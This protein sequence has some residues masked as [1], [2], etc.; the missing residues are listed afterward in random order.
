MTKLFFQS[1]TCMEKSRFHCADRTLK[2]IRNFFQTQP[3]QIME[4][5]YYAL[6]KRKG[7][8]SVLDSISEFGALGGGF[9]RV[10][11]GADEAINQSLDRSPVALVPFRPCIA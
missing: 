1:S 10:F 8:D 7:V 9:W 6:A 5:N 3:I 2:D 11:R 4:D